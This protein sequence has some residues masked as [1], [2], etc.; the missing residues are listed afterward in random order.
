MDDKQLEQM[1]TDI[2]ELKKEIELIFDFLNIE[3]S[4]DT[5]KIK[6]KSEQ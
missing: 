2:N 5:I 4:E 6:T 3:K 1:Q